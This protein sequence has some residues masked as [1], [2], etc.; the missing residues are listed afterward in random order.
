M[1]FMI[2]YK[3]SLPT[4]LAGKERF[5]GTGGAPAPNGVQKVASYHYADGSGGYTIAE[6]NNP[7]ALA[8]WANEWTDVL[9]MDIRPILND[10]QLGQVLSQST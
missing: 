3:T 1:L 8:T 5:I 10:E 9:A 6:T 2:A 7:V 4:S